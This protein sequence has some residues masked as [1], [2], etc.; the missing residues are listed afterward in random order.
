MSLRL[1]SLLALLAAFA[2]LTAVALLEVGYVG[3][4]ASASQGWG[5]AQVFADLVVL[6]VLA[7]IWM[8]A[9]ARARAVSPWPFVAI[10]LVGG[11]FGP[12]LYLVMREV[13]S[14]RD[15]QAAGTT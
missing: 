9:D 7:C 4:I 13:R 6:A 14:Q 10:T 12:L 11:S 5:P 1:I 15:R 2:T 3:I 8:I